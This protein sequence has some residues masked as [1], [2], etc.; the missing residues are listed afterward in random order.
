[1]TTETYEGIARG[2]QSTDTPSKSVQMQM[3]AD[4]ASLLGGVAVQGGMTTVD[5]LK[6][7]VALMVIATRAEKQ[8]FHLAVV[9][10]NGDVIADVTG[11]MTPTDLERKT[12][13]ERAEQV[14]T[15][16]REALNAPI[17]DKSK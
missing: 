14:A 17:S 13:D 1:M 4:F 12:V 8:G 11:A 9:D 16:I 10:A 15:K 2:M 7:A 3:P 6:K 5:A